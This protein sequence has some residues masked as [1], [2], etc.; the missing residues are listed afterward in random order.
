MKNKRRLFVAPLVVL[1]LAQLAMS[2]QWSAKGPLIREGHTANF[3]PVSNKMIVFGGDTSESTGRFHLND[4]WYLSNPFSTSG[5]ESWSQRKPTGT[6]PSP[7]IDATA[8]YNPTLNRLIVFGGAGG[9]AA[10]C[11]NDVWVLTNANGAGTTTP[12]WVQLAPTG[13]L[14]GVRFAHAAAYDAA[15]D[16]MIIFGGNNCF[17]ADYNDVWVLTNASGAGGTPNWTQVPDNGLF[18][19]PPPTA[20]HNTTAVYDP[21]T[22]RMMVYGGFDI[23]SNAL[24]DFWFFADGNGTSGGGCWETL[25]P[26][27]PHSGIIPI[28][29]SSRGG[30]SAT[31]DAVNNRMIV[32]GGDNS[33]GFMNDLWVLDN[34]SASAN[35]QNVVPNWVSV[36]PPG[37]LPMK[38]VSHTAI[39]NPSLK[40]LSIFGGYIQPNNG[41]C[42]DDF[43]SDVW[44]L[45][46]PSL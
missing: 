24:G 14:P 31:Y 4:V 7:R 13:T 37:L 10:P 3:D 23:N 40:R 21:S 33:S 6:P 35:G 44:V 41:C 34:A 43:A 32:F 12:A 1:L 28:C 36:S 38:R 18:C 15:H 26:T 2:Q 9:F 45:T 17:S 19:A 11:F 39:Y 20:R 22:N 25:T 8:V 27:C 42:G 29:P 5:N 46:A 16:I 30:H